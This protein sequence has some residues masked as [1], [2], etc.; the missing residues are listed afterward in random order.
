MVRLVKSVYLVYEVLSNVHMDIEPDT[1]A[2]ENA[3]PDNTQNNT[4]NRS[5]AEEGEDAFIQVRSK[6]SMTYN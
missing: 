6:C 4:P 3:P 2:P 5:R 1:T